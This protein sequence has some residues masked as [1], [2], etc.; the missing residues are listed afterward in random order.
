MSDLDPAEDDGAPWRALSD[1][2]M[3]SFA[4]PRILP[5]DRALA[6]AGLQQLQVAASSPLGAVALNCSGIL[7]YDGWLRIFGGSPCAEFGL[8]SLG[9]VN[10]FPALLDRTWTPTAGL[11]VAHD[12]LGGVFFLNGL[13]PGPGRPG[14]P[15]EVIYFDPPSLNWARMKMSHSEWLAWCVSGDL[16]HFYGDLLWPRWREDVRGLRADQGIAVVPALW[17]GET[18]GGFARS[19]ASMT[20]ILTLQAQAAGAKGRPLDSSLGYYP[21]DPVANATLV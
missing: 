3:R 17:S 5:P 14:V 16:P 18:A 9:E 12:V 7:L 13:R 21:G 19:V 6:R 8:P 11:I 1:V 15:G 2:L 10:D 20:D 4:A